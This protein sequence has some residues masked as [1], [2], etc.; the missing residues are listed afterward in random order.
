[1]L[2]KEESIKKEIIT[3]FQ[4]EYNRSGRVPKKRDYGHISKIEKAFGSWTEGLIE[5]GFFRRKKL[6]EEQRENVKRLNLELN[7]TCRARI[8]K[9]LTPPPELESMIVALAA[10]KI[11]RESPGQVFTRQ[12]INKGLIRMIGSEVPCMSNVF[13]IMHII[14]HRVINPRKGCYVFYSQL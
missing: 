14:D 12:R 7:N 8:Q 1:M 4:E 11:M 5:A 13:N 10:V 6:T 9:G 3:R 2:V